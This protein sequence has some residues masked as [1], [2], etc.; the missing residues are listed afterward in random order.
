MYT[1][2]IKLLHKHFPIPEHNL[3]VNDRP[4]THRVGLPNSR[5]TLPG[6]QQGGG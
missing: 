4:T 3:R 1:D 2:Q 5:N 6:I